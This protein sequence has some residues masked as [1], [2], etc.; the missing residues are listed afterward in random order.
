MDNFLGR[1]FFGNPVLLLTL[2]V[3][4]HVAVLYLLWRL[5]RALE[6]RPLG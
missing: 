6:R 4:W 1:F 2:N 3:L 5:V